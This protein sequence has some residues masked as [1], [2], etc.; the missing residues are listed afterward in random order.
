MQ[1]GFVPRLFDPYYTSIIGNA[2]MVLTCYL[3]SW[4]FPARQRDL[5]NLTVWDSTSKSVR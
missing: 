4:V 1:Y 2:V 5:T 3:A